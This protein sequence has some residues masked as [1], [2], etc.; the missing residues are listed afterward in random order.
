MSDEIERLALPEAGQLRTN[1][2][3]LEAGQE[4]LMQRVNGLPTASDLWR[5]ATLIGL[6]GGVVGIVGIEWLW[7]HL[8][9]CGPTLTV[10]LPFWLLFLPMM[11]AIIGV[12]VGAAAASLWGRLIGR[13]LG[14]LIR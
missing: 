1:I 2:A 8:P 6:I 3:N 12:G 10:D 7:R 13:F 4:F 14:R 5:I 9:V 11:V